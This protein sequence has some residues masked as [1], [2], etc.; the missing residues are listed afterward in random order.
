MF[1]LRVRWT[2]TI[3]GV[4]GDP[5]GTERE[6]TTDA[7]ISYRDVLAWAHALYLYEGGMDGR[8]WLRRLAYAPSQDGYAVDEVHRCVWG[9]V[10]RARPGWPAIDVRREVRALFAAWESDIVTE[11]RGAWQRLQTAASID[12]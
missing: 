12:G 1:V 3:L 11:R 2:A 8:D 10:S 5:R 9:A 4:F 7:A 6:M